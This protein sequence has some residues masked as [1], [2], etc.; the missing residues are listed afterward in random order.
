M[1]I[2]V[3]ARESISAESSGAPAAEDEA[4]GFFTA[5]R[6]EMGV[7]LSREERCAAEAGDDAKDWGRAADSWDD[8]VGDAGGR[9]A[10]GVVLPPDVEEFCFLG[11]L[12]AMDHRKH[13]IG[14]FKSDGVE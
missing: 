12:E 3:S 1:I 9:D 2:D 7:P 5:A 8:G 14:K 6:A 13:S 4:V 10:D 11:V